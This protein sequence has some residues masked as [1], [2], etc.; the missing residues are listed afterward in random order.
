MCHFVLSILR[1]KRYGLLLSK[2]K[3]MWCDLFLCDIGNGE[4]LSPLVYQS[5]SQKLHSDIINFHLG[6]KLRRCP[7]K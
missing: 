2:L 4:T 6:T 5:I 7:S 1:G 3:K